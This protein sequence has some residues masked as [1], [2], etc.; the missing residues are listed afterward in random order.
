MQFGVDINVGCCSRN[1]RYGGESRAMCD[2]TRTRDVMLRLGKGRTH[3]LA[4]ELG[5][6]A[7]QVVRSRPDVVD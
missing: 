1:A 4:A 2:K 7:F 6:D 3:V 5:V